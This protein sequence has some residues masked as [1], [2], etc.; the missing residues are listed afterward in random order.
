MNR[1]R[2]DVHRRRVARYF[3]MDDASGI[4]RWGCYGCAFRARHHDGAILT[5]AY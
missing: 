4:V 1:I 3:W 5:A 2:C